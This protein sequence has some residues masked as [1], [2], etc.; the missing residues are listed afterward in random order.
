MDEY[1]PRITDLPS[2][3]RPRERLLHVGASAV[4]TIELLAIILRVGTGG[5]NVMRVAQ[6][7]LV[8]FGGLGGLARAST[9]E[10]CAEKGLGEAKVAQLKAAFELGRRLLVE[11]PEERPTITSPADA[12]NLLLGEMGLLE[13]ESMRVILLDTRN[14]V[15]LVVLVYRGSVNSSQVKV[16]EVFKEAVRRNAPNIILVHNHPE[17]HPVPS[18]LDLEMTKKL[19]DLAAL[20]GIKLLDHLIVTQ[21]QAYSIK[22][23]KLL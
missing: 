5:E 14:R 2:D 8:K 11:S 3:E 19:E 10:L 23:G 21:Q 17:G 1:Q 20:F 16:G 12:A 13:Q 18:D 4:S 9:S 6:R 22:T 15:D 7:L